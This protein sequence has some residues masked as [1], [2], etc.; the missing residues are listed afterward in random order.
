MPTDPLCP[1]DIDSTAR[2]A[3]AYRKALNAAEAIVSF[4]RIADTNF[5]S[6]ATGA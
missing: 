3:P 1:Y 6:D 4:V 5:A 2:S